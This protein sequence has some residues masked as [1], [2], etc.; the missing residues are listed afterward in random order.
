MKVIFSRGWLP[1]LFT[2]ILIPSLVHAHTGV[3]STIGFT[4]GV[5]HPLGGIDH[6]LAMVAVGIWG[7]YR[8]C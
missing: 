5:N 1:A 2:L 6:I 8:E 7:L 3:G 4:Y